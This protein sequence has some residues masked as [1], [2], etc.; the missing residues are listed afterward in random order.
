MTAAFLSD[1]KIQLFVLRL[2]EC[3]HV[4]RDVCGNGNKLWGMSAWMGNRSEKWV[5]EWKV[6][7]QGEW[8]RVQNLF[9]S[10]GI[11]EGMYSSSRKVSILWQTD[12]RINEPT[13]GQV[14]NITPHVSLA[15]RRHKNHYAHDI[16]NRKL[17]RKQSMSYLLPETGTEKIRYQ[18]RVRRV[19]NHYRFSR[20]GSWRRFLVSV[21]CADRLNLF[22]NVY[23]CQLT[24]EAASININ[25]NEKLRASSPGS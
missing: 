17:A 2:W 20:T 11:G 8:V 7:H 18:T 6:L 15:R 14:D 5:W 9:L 24:I 23:I 25:I 22:A 16:H 10:W 4:L 3:K 1:K 21:S 19:R 12:G 13:D